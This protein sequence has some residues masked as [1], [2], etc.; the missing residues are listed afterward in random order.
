VEILMPLDQSSE[1]R[2]HEEMDK[3][4]REGWERDA[5]VSRLERRI[6]QIGGI[7][8]GLVV[9]GIGLP[10]SYFARVATSFW[11]YSVIVVSAVGLIAL[12]SWTF[13]DFY[14]SPR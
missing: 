8:L 5:R 12:A 3:V 13:R 7:V 4:R 1:A 9:L 11:G 10:F 2:L 6:M 14:R